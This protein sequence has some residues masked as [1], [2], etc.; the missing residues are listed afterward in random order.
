MATKSPPHVLDRWLQL[1]ATK[2]GVHRLYEVTEKPG[3][4]AKLIDEVRELVRG[5]YGSADVIARRLSELGAKKTAALIAEQ[6]PRTKK[7]RSG[8]V[9]EILATELAERELGFEIPIRRLRWKDGREMALRGDDVLGVARG[10][11]NA[12]RILKGESK[13]RAVL[14]SGVV[15]EAG[16]ALD[17]AG[18]RPTRHTV[19]FVADRL[20]EMKEDDLALELERSVLASFSGVEV[21]HLIFVLCGNDPGQMLTTHLA[22]STAK[23]RRRHA[24]G[25]HLPDH[26]KAISSLFK[27]P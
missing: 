23:K 3:T 2:I 4:R 12:L 6:L 19:L 22:S 20:R 8:D 21:E 14:A 13:S 1:T 7:A 16:A 25:V 10:P 17:R 5:H 15:E 27:D 9:G 11:K 24:I 18:G 26:A